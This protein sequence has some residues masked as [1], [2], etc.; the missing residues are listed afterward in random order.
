LKPG[1][2]RAKDMHDF[3]QAIS[4]HLFEVFNDDGS[5]QSITW[6][7]METKPK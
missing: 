4:E 7:N 1:G 3:L 2:I 5:I 6:K